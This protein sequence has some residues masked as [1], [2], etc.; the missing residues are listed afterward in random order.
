MVKVL[1]LG[2][3]SCKT[4][5]VK[6]QKLIE[7]LNLDVKLIYITDLKLIASYNITTMP[8]LIINEKVICYGRIPNDEKLKEFVLNNIKK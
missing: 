1:G 4:L 6:L 8:I 7:E 5:Y 2:C 3:I